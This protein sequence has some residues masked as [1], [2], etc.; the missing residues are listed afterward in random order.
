MFNADVLRAR[1]LP[2]KPAKV[3][4]HFALYKDGIHPAPL[5][6]ATWTRKIQLEM[7]MDC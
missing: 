5:L 4:P 2:G 3:T 1:K 7:E 6:A